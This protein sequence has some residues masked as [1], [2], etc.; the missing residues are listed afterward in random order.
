MNVT[1]RR[2]QLPR[3]LEVGLHSVREEITL[4][5]Q[6]T[7]PPVEAEDV[8]V[9]AQIELASAA[10]HGR[11]D[12]AGSDSVAPAAFG[13]EDVFDDDC[14]GRDFDQPDAAHD[15]AVAGDEGD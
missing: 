9:T 13:N 4:Q 5:R 8:L 12:Q 2:I 10:V 15:P 11:L 3:A 6:E 14:L 1:G 7:E